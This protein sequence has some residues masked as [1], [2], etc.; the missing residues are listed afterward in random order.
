[1]NPIKTDATQQRTL[2]NAEKYV[3]IQLKIFAY[4]GMIGAFK[5]TPNLTIE[6]ERNNI[7]LGKLCLHTMDIMYVL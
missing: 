7:L 5:I 3:I 4:N 2:I 1:M 6:E